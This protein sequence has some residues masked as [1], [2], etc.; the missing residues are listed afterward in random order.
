MTIDETT[1]NRIIDELCAARAEDLAAIE[2]THDAAARAPKPYS[3]EE[4]RAFCEAGERMM[5]AHFR[6]IDALN[7]LH[8]ALSAT[9]YRRPKHQANS[10]AV[11]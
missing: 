4:M 10:N 6:K 2:L 8:A 1:M 7:N 9:E 11:H 5:R 3:D